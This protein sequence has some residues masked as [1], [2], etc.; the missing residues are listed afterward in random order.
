MNMNMNM[1]MNVD[2]NMN[3]TSKLHMDDVCSA[4]DMVSTASVYVFVLTVSS[5]VWT[6][7]S[8]SFHQSGIITLPFIPRHIR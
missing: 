1:N 6:E 8:K 7:H 2:A 3:F 5:V 4:I